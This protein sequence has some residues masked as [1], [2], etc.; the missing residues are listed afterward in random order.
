M[1]K[2]HTIDGGGG[3]G[4]A[5]AGTATATTKTTPPRPSGR[6]STPKRK[7]RRKSSPVSPTAIAAAASARSKKTNAS[8]AAELAMSSSTSSAS[9]YSSSSAVPAGLLAAMSG[10]FLASTPLAQSVL[11]QI[12]SRLIS[13][14][15]TSKGPVWSVGFRRL[16]GDRDGALDWDEFEKVMRRQGCKLEPADV[17]RL[18][19][20][21]DVNGSGSVEVDDFC[22]F[23]E[24]QAALR[25]DAGAFECVRRRRHLR[26]NMRVRPPPPFLYYSP[27]FFKFP[28]HPV[29]TS[30]PITS[31]VLRAC[32]RRCWPATTRMMNPQTKQRNSGAAEQDDDAAQE[33]AAVAAPAPAAAGADAR[34]ARAVPVEAARAAGQRG[35]GVDQPPAPAR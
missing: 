25:T 6:P 33:A 21:M 29:R 28:R 5:A 31:R 18:F 32:T 14:A 26:S 7:I 22:E 17:V 9:S 13:A 2:S 12:V 15:Y 10:P 3:D 30:H 34:H 19:L 35:R 20:L 1:D 8:N 23:M 16:D 11:D 4:A 24:E 27:F